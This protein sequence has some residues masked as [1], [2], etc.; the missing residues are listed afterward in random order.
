MIA[1]CTVVVTSPAILPLPWTNLASGEAFF[2]AKP[3]PLHPGLYS[4][5]QCPAGPW[6]RPFWLGQILSGPP[7]AHFP[8][9]PSLVFHFESISGSDTC[10]PMP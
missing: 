3:P 8:H 2:S 4:Q 6:P 7:L 5:P 9:T 1:I 10:P